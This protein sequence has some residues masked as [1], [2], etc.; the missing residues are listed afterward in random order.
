MLSI[1]GDRI[2]WP[3][4]RRYD[5]QAA[6][7]QAARDRET[8]HRGFWGRITR[9]VMGHPW[10]S[11]ILSAGLLILLALPYLSM[12]QGLSGVSDLPDTDTKRAFTVLSQQFSAG[13]VSPVEV[14]VDGPASDPRVQGAVTNFTAALGKD[15]IYGPVTVQSNQPGDLT[16]ISFPLNVKPD[17]VEGYDAVRQLRRETIPAAFAGAPAQVLVSGQTAVAVDLFKITDDYTPIV[18]AF[19][20]G[21]TLLLLM[22]AFRSIVVPVKAI[23]MNL[24]SVG[25]AYGLL[26]AVFQKGWGNELFGFRQVDTIETWLPLF[27]FSIL[28]GLSM[29]YHVFLLSRIRE[30][31]S[32][33]HNNSESVAVGLQATGKII[34]GAALIM[35]VVFSGFAAGRLVSL[36]QTGFGL[37]VAV[38]LD[39]TVVRSVLVPATMALLGDRNWYLPSWL[40]WLPDLRIEG[41]AAAPPIAQPQGLSAD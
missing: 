10:V 22:L 20:L 32:Q 4:R 3:R 14:V 7:A 27:L 30:H 17:G 9:I 16:L 21:L 11:V 19:V 35:V 13:L 26:V 15:P 18:F 40:R 38:L 37:A 25:A 6:A 34:T 39:A 36:Q 28:F 12:K 29:D 5:A 31:Y 8:I 24:L 23:I 1:L 33:T 2:N 41:T